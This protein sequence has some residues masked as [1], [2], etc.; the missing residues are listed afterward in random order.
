M[1]ERVWHKIIK[2]DGS[3]PR[4][5]RCL[6]TMSSS[7]HIFKP[8]IVSVSLGS[9]EVTQV[10]SLAATDDTCDPRLMIPLLHKIQ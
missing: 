7:F 5:L 6:V 3:Q 8:R 1:R 10:N 9:N 4:S 2:V